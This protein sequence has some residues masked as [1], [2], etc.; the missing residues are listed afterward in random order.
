METLIHIELTTNWKLNVGGFILWQ[1][2]CDR[3]ERTC[4][5]FYISTDFSAGLRMCLMLAPAWEGLK[6]A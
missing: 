3:C 4:S 5:S 6:G 1:Q 2:E